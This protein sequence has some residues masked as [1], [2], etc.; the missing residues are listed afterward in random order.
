MKLKKQYQ[1]QPKPFQIK[2]AS[3]FF[4]YLTEVEKKAISA[5]EYLLF[6]FD[7]GC[8]TIKRVI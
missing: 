4:E 1:K 3:E 2:E 6:C 5:L 8:K 7:N